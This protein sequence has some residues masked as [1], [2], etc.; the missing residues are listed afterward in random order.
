M[1][2]LEVVPV[3]KKPMDSLISRCSHKGKVACSL[4]MCQVFPAERVN[5]WQPNQPNFH[6]AWNNTFCAIPW[7][8]E[9]NK[10]TGKL[11]FLPPFEV[12]FRQE[13]PNVSMLIHA[14]LESNF[15]KQKM[16][17]F[18]NP[19]LFFVIFL[20]AQTAAVGFFLFSLRWLRRGR[21]SPCL[22]SD[23]AFIG[24]K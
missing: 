2:Y 1:L 19:L 11:N 12:C 22:L 15:S 23:Q 6:A 4:S 18:P 14:N 10:S 8:H 17:G 7:L 20:D 13:I 3:W 24:V 5:F 9:R 21:G 16:A